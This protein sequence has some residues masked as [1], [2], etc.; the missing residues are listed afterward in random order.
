[1][2]DVAVWVG[3]GEAGGSLGCVC[4]WMLAEGKGVDVELA[5]L[6]VA[7]LLL[8]ASWGVESGGW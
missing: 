3:A 5:V 7:G 2:G 6:L 8:G 4:G 1:M